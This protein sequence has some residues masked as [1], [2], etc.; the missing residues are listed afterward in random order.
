M[1]RRAAFSSIILLAFCGAALAQQRPVGGHTSGPAVGRNVT[2]ST[3][4]QKL[5]EGR[6]S[7]AG[8][9]IE[10][11]LDASALSAGSPGVAGKPGTQSGQAPKG[12]DAASKA[13]Y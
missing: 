8:E 7:F 3:V 9:D 4:T 10:A 2:P 12:R 1:R 13:V 11:A 5:F 6:S